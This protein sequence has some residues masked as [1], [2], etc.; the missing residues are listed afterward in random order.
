MIFLAIKTRIF[1][2]QVLSPMDACLI[3]SIATYDTT[4]MDECL[5][6]V[7]QVKVYMILHN[8]LVRVYMKIS[9][10]LKLIMSKVGLKLEL[11]RI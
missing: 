5:Q 9:L 2:N 3:G 8:K 4:W 6:F 11:V 10:I 1:N 7:L